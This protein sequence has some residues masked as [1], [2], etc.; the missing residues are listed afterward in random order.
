MRLP[1]QELCGIDRDRFE[2]IYEGTHA[3]HPA[4]V[5]RIQRGLEICFEPEDF[6]EY[7]I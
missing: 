7:G 2:D 3:P 6:E 1:E 5:L 4:D